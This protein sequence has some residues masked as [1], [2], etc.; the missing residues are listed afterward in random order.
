MYEPVQK[1][2]VIFTQFK[3]ICVQ[4]RGLAAGYSCD[5]HSSA[6]NPGSVHTVVCY[7]AMVYFSWSNDI[8]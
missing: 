5:R 2:L 3:V 8:P 7:C 1:R 6:T 4:C